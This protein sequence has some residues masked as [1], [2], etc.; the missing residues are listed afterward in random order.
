MVAVLLGVDS[1]AL[2]HELNINTIDMLDQAS[3]RWKDLLGDVPVDVQLTFPPGGKDLIWVLG[4]VC[5]LWVLLLRVEWFFADDIR[6][7]VVDQ[8]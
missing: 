1:K 3:D 8:L 6:D 7:K 2:C 5:Q 4:F